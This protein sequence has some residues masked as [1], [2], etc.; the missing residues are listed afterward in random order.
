[1]SAR[2][3]IL[4]SGSGTT[5]QNLAD[6]IA[7]GALPAE[8][9]VVVA[10]RPGIFGIER[11]KQLGHPCIVA[12]DPTEALRAHRAEFVAMCGWMRYWDPPSD[13]RGKT[14]NVHP[15]L[16]PAF[17]GKGMFGHHVHE[18]VLKHGCKITGCTVHFVSGGYDTG[19]ILA[20]QAVQVADGDTPDT[21]AA[22]V[23]A[24]ERD[25]YPKTIAQL[26]SQSR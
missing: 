21:L 3:G 18:A 24:A 5:Y 7:D 16:L 20:Q 15:S 2:L 23:Q 25:L 8:I 12:A 10:S 6:R 11:A 17:G 22:R 26:I 9:V 14:I 4:L 19:P 1:M 13:F